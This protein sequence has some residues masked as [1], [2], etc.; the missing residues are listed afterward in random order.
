MYS[1]YNVLRTE[2]E[3]SLSGFDN[4]WDNASLQIWLH[5]EMYR[6][7]CSDTVSWFLSRRLIIGAISSVRLKH[8]K[9]KTT[10]LTDL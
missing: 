5:T 10:L 6:S 4:S 2:L 7:R 9:E 3:T 1:L 8:A